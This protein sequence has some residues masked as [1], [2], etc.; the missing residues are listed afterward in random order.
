MLQP[1]SASPGTGSGVFLK[2]AKTVCFSRHKAQPTTQPKATSLCE[3]SPFGDGDA[4]CWLSPLCEGQQG[5]QEPP[6][7]ATCVQ[8]GERLHSASGHHTALGNHG[9]HL[10]RHAG[11]APLQM[12]C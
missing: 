8:G 6:Q 11:L 4:R 5:W 10:A 9:T 3:Q 1:A 7:H 12:S 2:P